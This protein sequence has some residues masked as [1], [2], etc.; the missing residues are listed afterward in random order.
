MAGTSS[1]RTTA[2]DA[3]LGRYLELLPLPL[4]RRLSQSSIQGRPLEC[5]SGTKL[6]TTMRRLRVRGNCGERMLQCIGEEQCAS[7]NEERAGAPRRRHR[8]MVA[9]V[10]MLR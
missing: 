2:I 3:G 7:R 8:E 5:A 9:E 6:P 10:D 1:D 4:M